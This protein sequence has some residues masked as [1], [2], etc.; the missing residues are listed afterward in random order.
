MQICGFNKTTLLD[1]PDH[2][3]CGIFLGGCNFHCPFC[4]NGT[5]VM[6]PA[7]QPNIPKEDILAHLKKRKGILDGICISGGEPTL[8]PDLLD[9]MKE[10]K[11]LDYNIK[12]DTNGYKPDVVKTAIE[13]GLIDYVAMDIKSSLD[14]Y[15]K[16]CGKPDL[17][18]G[19]IAETVSLL[20]TTGIPHE[21]RTTVVKP[22]HTEASF[23]AIGQWLKGN[24]PYYLQEFIDSGDV[25][26]PDGLS[27]FSQ[28]EMLHFKEL[29]VPCLPNTHLRGIEE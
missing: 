26:C 29:L 4:Q 9:F 27:A 20:Q 15:P 19:R 28:E 14:E 13:K 5:L 23:E 7:T 18:T 17:D 3:A 22:L 8:A 11:E 1:Y 24:S 25:I 12:L 21:F 16:L 2:L 6:A 10:I